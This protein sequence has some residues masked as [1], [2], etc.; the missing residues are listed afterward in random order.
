[1]KK[2]LAIVL[3][4]LMALTLFACNKPATPGA[5]PGDVRVPPAGKL[6]RRRRHA[7]TPDPSTPG[8]RCPGAR[9]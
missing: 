3:V 5:P 7:W 1:M 2:I 4:L 9:R 8:H 6:P